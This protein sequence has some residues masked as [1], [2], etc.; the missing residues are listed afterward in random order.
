MYRTYERPIEGTIYISLFDGDC[1]TYTVFE[2]EEE[3]EMEQKR[4]K[5]INIEAEEKRNEYIKYLE[6]LEK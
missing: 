5:K 2:S 4:I 3:K 6:T 1:T